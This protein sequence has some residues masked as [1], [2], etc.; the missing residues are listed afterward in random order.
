MTLAKNWVETGHYG[1]F[2]LG[3]PQPPGLAG[4]FELVAPI[5]LSFYLFGV[6]VWQARVVGL[7]L[8]LGGFFTSFYLTDKLFN[9]KIAWGTVFALVLLV[10]HPMVNPLLIGRQVLGDIPVVFY[11]LI[12]YIFLWHGWKGNRWFLI[13]VWVFWGIALKTKGQ[14]LPFWLTSL[15]VPILFA[16]LKRQWKSMILLGISGMGAWVFSLMLGRAQSF[17]LL[18]HTVQQS[19]LSGYYQIIAFVTDLS[20]R[21]EALQFAL[22]VSLPVLMGLAYE[23][24]NKMRQYSSLDFEDRNVVLRLSLLFL[25][26]SWIAWYILFSNGGDRYLASPVFLS[27]PFISAMFYDFTHHFNLQATI[28]EISGIIRGSVNWVK[29]IKTFTTVFIILF[30]SGMTIIIFYLSIKG[31]SNGVIQA[32]SF[33][34]EQTD[35]E[36]VIESYDSELFVFLD[37]NY[38]FPPDQLHV[39][40]LRRLL[41]DSE[42]T[43]EYDPL[44]VDPDYL[45]VG[46]LSTNWQVY[47]DLIATD[48]FILLKEFPHYRIYERMR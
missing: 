38:H 4:S 21:M 27:G 19:G 10:P 3:E 41:L 14:T 5:A 39:E 31:A 34:N 48:K 8:T 9:R 30:Y 42:L 24:W 15:L 20:V 45:V 37:R 12:G 2:L 18:G 32:A 26:G 29:F 36:A 6:G 13:G 22:I 40:Y 46:R 17:I 44:R 47:D 23:F 11:L 16:L 33:I 1:Q 43:V 35:P 25:S 7:L 28:K